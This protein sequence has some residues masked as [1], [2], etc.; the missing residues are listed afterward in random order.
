MQRRF[1]FLL[2][3]LFCANLNAQNAD[4]RC[5]RYF[6][7]PPN[8][9]LD[10]AM[11]ITSGSVAPMMIAVPAGLLGYNLYTKAEN[12]QR[13]VPFIVGGSVIATSAICLGLKYGVNRERPFVAYNDIEQRTDCGP[14][15]FPSAHTGNAFALATS[16]S[17][18]YP[19]WYV[20]VPAYTWAIAVGYSRMRLGVHFPSDVLM[21]ALI[22]SA[23]AYGSYWVG[24]KLIEN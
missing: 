13:A 11:R 12:P 15:S 24:R 21:G 20:I 23:C 22:G 16:L 4:I 3:I 10:K 14:Y 18:C 9:G 5:L 7:H 1:T 19:K 6:N 2:A 8:A 17:L